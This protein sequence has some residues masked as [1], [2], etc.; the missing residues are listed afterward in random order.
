MRL[1]T[2]RSRS[3]RIF[4]A[5][6]SLLP[7]RHVLLWVFLAAGCGQMGLVA[8]AVAPGAPPPR[9]AQHRDVPL[10]ASTTPA[11]RHNRPEMAVVYDDTYRPPAKDLQLNLDS[12]R[13]ADAAARYVSGMLQE[14]GNPEAAGEQYLKSLAL[15]P[16]N[17]ELSVKLAQDYVRK[18]DVPAAINL[19]KDTIKAAPKQA[20]PYLALGYIYYNQQNKADLAQ[21]CILDS[22]DL[23]PAQIRG[24]DYLRTIYRDTRQTDKI[25]PL[26]ERA[27]KVETDDSTFWLY[28]GKLFIEQYLTNDAS[29]VPGDPLRKTTAVFQKAF[30]HGQNE[31]EVI[32]KVADFFVATKQFKEAIPVYARVIELDPA[33][34]SPRENLAR[35]YMATEQPHKAAEALEGLLKVNSVDAHAY[36]TLAKLY[37]DDG[38]LDKAAANYEQSLLINPNDLEGYQNVFEL[39]LKRKQPEK[40]IA[41][42]T[43]ARK[44]FSGQPAFTYMLAIS[45]EEAKQH[46][47]ALA[48]YAEAETEAMRGMPSLL[49]S[50]FYFAYGTA[51]EQAGLYDRAG[52]LLKKALELEDSDRRV[53]IISN[54][55]GYMWVDHSLNLEEGGNLIKRALEIDPDNAAYLDSLGWYYYRTDRFED[56]E[57]ELT[58]AAELTKPEDSEVYIHLGDTY[59]KLNNTDKAVASWQKAVD[60]N[61][62]NTDVAALNKKIAEAKASPPSPKD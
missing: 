41:L 47:E 24:Y 50:R 3:E 9:P 11:V 62:N 57:K 43:D 17:V 52:V 26:L 33:Q 60:L 38:Q 1:T 8:A 20:K 35:C 2:A 10:G 51:A 59:A 14:E 49:D 15:D 7:L 23:D 40:A 36:A 54:Y 12:E 39:Q 44:R 56:A 53:A 28:L 32:N 22:L 46:K 55:L 13:K 37:E 45:Q 6:G 61:T 30:D 16:G 21:K 27:A 48:S 18:G 42:L 58:K 19:L 34:V 4:R 5:A 25:P 29:L 31:P